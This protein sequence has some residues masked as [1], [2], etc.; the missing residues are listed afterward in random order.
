MLPLF[1][2]SLLASPG[3]NGTHTSSFDE[4]QIKAG[5]IYRF[6]SFVSWERQQTDDTIT[7][8]ILGNNPF[9]KAFDTI[10]GSS[11]GT[12]TIAIER[13]PDTSDLKRIRS[14]D[15]VF[16][17]IADNAK[18]KRTLND[19]ANSSTLTI[20]DSKDFIDQGGMIGF[21]DKPDGK[22]GIELNIGAARRDGLTIRSMLKRI[23]VRII[24]DST[25]LGTN[26]HA[27]I[28]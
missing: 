28:R 6:L 1:A 7:I 3:V 9:G 26:R 12:K 18:V 24:N 23:A 17:A 10:N 5:F 4:Y 2:A 8:G 21:V 14:C 15:I 11:F 25:Y 22:I 19:L 20:G 13:I 16:V 27:A